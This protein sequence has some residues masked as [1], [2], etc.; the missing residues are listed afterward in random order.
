ME[1]QRSHEPET[2]VDRRACRRVQATCPAILQ[3]MTTLTNGTLGDISETGARFEAVDPPGAGAT[4]L[5]RWGSHEAVCTIVWSE[6]DSCGVVFKQALPAEVVAE[7]AAL[8]CVREIP[9]ASVGNITQGRRRSSTFLKVA[10]VEQPV[11]PAAPS[12]D[13]P[14]VAGSTS[15]LGEVLAR[16][17]RTRTWER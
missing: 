17:R 10:P 14:P 3:T 11:P 12:P 5:L 2:V 15:S 16:F 4:A 9:I 1:P 13:P 6:E 7:T 8:T